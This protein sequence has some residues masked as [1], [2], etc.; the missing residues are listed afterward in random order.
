MRR[1]N[2]KR[3]KIEERLKDAYAEGTFKACSELGKVKWTGEQIDN[4]VNGIRRLV[5]LA[6]FTG[7]VME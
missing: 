3:G 4:Y 7:T 1:S 2:R 5:G 6:G